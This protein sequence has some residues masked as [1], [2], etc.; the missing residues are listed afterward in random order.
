[1]RKHPFA[2]VPLLFLLVACGSEDMP[3]LPP[4]NPGL[5]KLTIDPPMI[6][7][8]IE[9]SQPADVDFK[10]LG[11]FSGETTPRD[12]SRR[13]NWNVADDS[14]GTFGVDAV[15]YRFRSSATRGGRTTVTANSY[16]VMPA[17]ANV[18]IVYSANLLRPDALPKSAELF[19]DATEEAS[20]GPKIVAPSTGTMLEK[21]GASQFTWAGAAGTDLFELSF[22]N[23]VTDLRIY[24]KESKLTLSAE[25]W[26]ILSTTNAGSEVNVH[27]RGMKSSSPANAGSSEKITVAFPK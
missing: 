1:M 24:T 9:G 11:T 25:E 14:L 17:V 4:K 19:K 6:N 23:D 8:R 15:M 22:T 12:I 18:T 10:A 26:I 7:L 5:V 16:P 13:V 20:L 2:A 27:V 21:G 3:D